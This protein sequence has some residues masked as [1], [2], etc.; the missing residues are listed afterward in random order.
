[1]IGILLVSHEPLGTAL[2]NCTR[3]IFGRLPVQLAALDVIPDEDPQAALQAARELL[4][5]INDGTGALGLTDVYGATPSRIAVQLAAAGRVAVV[6]GVN[7][8]LLIKALSHRREP[9]TALVLML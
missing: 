3:H 4:A 9:L 2:L 1:M 5:R 8:P 7:L 6:A